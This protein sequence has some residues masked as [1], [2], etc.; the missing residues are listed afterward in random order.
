MLDIV[1]EAVAWLLGFVFGE[2]PERPLWLR[3][4]VAVLYVLVV[5][6]CLVAAVVMLT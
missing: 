1:V 3:R 6:A 2:L 5:A 4:V